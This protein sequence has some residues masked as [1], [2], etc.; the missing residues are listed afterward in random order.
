MSKSRKKLVLFCLLSV[1]FWALAL[2]I[3]PAVPLGVCNQSAHL[4]IDCEIPLTIIT[5]LVIAAGYAFLAAKFWR[6]KLTGVD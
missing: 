4:T 5:L 3:L 6:S 1:V 2:L